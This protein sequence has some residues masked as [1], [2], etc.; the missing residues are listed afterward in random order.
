MTSEKRIELIATLR[1]AS[2]EDTHIWH[3][4]EADLRTL[5]ADHRVDVAVMSTEHG[6]SPLGAASEYVSEALDVPYD[7]I[8]RL[9]DWNRFENEQVTLV[10][11]RSRR[12]DGALKGL[13]LAPGETALCYS[14]FATPI[15]GRPHRDFYYNV[16][17]EAIAYA[18]G[19]WAARL[20][21]I[22]HLSASGR[23]HQDIA[24]CTAEATVHVDGG[25]GCHVESLVFFGCCINEA[26]LQALSL[27]NAQ[28]RGSVHRPIATVIEPNGQVDVIHL[29]WPRSRST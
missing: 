6:F 15:Y 4:P 2:G 27:L 19:R 24:L 22:S 20:V 28:A 14:K 8:K 9:A 21:G 13:I 29:S 25:S 12:K 17:Y 16:T 5:A 18:A 7:E 3:A 10:A 1:S 26:S 11:V 23:F